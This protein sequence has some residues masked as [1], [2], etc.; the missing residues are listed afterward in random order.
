MVVI[1]IICIGVLKKRERY[2]SFVLL[3]KQKLN[4][5][6]SLIIISILFCLAAVQAQESPIKVPE[7]DWEELQKTKPW[8]ATEYYEP[9]PPKVT[10]GVWTAPPSDAIVLFDGSDMNSWRMSDLNYGVNMYQMEYISKATFEVDFNTRKPSKWRIED[11]QMVVV[12]G[13][14]AIETSRLFGDVQLHIEWL[15]PVDPGKEGQQYSNSGVF[16][17]GQY[18]VQILNNYDNPT[19]VNGQASS[20]YKQQP[21]LVNASRKPGE[22]QEYEIIFTAPRFDDEGNLQSPA[23]VTVFHN[24]VLTQ[25]H[26]ELTGPTIYIG[27]PQYVA[28]KEKLPLLLQDHGNEVRFRNIWIR[29]L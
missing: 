25:N 17:M 20:L 29:E 11:G 2:L 14:G 13:S 18:E 22:W 4:V 3:L 9:I 12:P 26:V 15:A 27:K 23:Y 7:V 24:G 16:F 6:R 21:P 19:Y 5:M 10:P 28:H 8:E 1:L